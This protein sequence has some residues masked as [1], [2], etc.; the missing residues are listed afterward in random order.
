MSLQRPIETPLIELPVQ[1]SA[2]RRST[3]LAISLLVALTVGDSVLAVILFDLFDER[4]S[5]FVNQGTALVYIVVSLIALVAMRNAALLPARVVDSSQPVIDAEGNLVGALRPERKVPWYYLVVIGLLNGSA[6][7]L[8]AISQP[9]TPGLSQTLLPLLGIPLVL[10][11][12]WLLFHRRPSLAGALGAA[13]IIG[14]GAV[15]ALRTVLATSTSDS[16]SGDSPIVVYGWAIALFGSAQVFLAFEK[17]FEERVFSDFE[18]LNPMV[19]FCWT[20]VTQFLLGWALYPLQT[21][22]AFGGI[23]ISDLPDVLWDGVRC[24]V[25][26]TAAGCGPIHAIIFWCY[27]AVDFWCYYLGL[28]LIQRFGASMMVI[29]SAIALPLSQLVLCLRPIVGKWTEDFFWGD[30]LALVLVLAGFMVYHC[31]SREGQADR[32]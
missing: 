12:V 13:L 11:L 27:C 9:H 17:V 32:R 21:F 28:W 1:P 4:L 3:V 8:Q 2:S 6:N 24:T 18:R 22:P 30:G 23:S 19:M 16:G 26:M 20:L 7:F 10:V 31:Y 15:S 14:G 5:L 29:A 25:G